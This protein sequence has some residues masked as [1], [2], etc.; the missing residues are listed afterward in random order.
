MENLGQNLGWLEMV[1][2]GVTALGW[3]F[4]QL[5]SVNREIAEDKAK[6]EQNEAREYR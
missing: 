4:W 3:G 1:F 6:R 5:W 2:F